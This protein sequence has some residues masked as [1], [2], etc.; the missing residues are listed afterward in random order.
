M[1]AVKNTARVNKKLDQVAKDIDRETRRA[2]ISGALLVEKSAERRILRG[3]KTGRVYMRDSGRHR[4]SAPGQPPAN[5]TGTL[6][7]SIRHWVLDSG[8]K[9][10]VGSRLAYASILEFG[11]R[12]MAARPWL[13]PSL[14][15]NKKKITALLAQAIKKITK[16]AKQ[17]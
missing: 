5:D 1:I 2:L 12:M 3:P 14:E 8:L 10:E 9:V 11:S 6:V 13:H 17:K 15:E 7:S 16:K 4:A